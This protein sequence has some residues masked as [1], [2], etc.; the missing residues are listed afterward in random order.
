[1]DYKQTN[2]PALKNIIDQSG[3]N[4]PV[5]LGCLRK[6]DLD[7]AREILNRILLATIGMLLLLILVATIII[8][9][10]GSLKYHD[11]ELTIQ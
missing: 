5:A 1:M 6:K 10:N 4:T 11:C 3:F 7:K 8:M 2:M 9:M